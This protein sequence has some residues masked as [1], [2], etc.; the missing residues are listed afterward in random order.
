M[1]VV[2]DLVLAALG[3][4]IAYFQWSAERRAAAEERKEQEDRKEEK[5]IIRSLLSRVA[6]AEKTRG[7]LKRMHEELSTPH[8]DP[9][10]ITGIFDEA[11]ERYESNFQTVRPL[12]KSI[13]D[14]LLKNEERFPMSHG[15]GR[16][17]TELREILNY[18]AV[19]RERRI[20]GYDA[21][22]IQTHEI[23]MDAWN[24]RGGQLREQDRAE[25]GSLAET[26]VQ[27]LE[28]YYHHADRIGSVLY[29]LQAKYRAK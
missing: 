26:M 17:I 22:R 13:Y 14:E 20:L 8:T 15:Y 27:T 11:I 21:A 24:N 7:S 5:V 28:P 2:I 19:V 1:D 18:D 25:L 3:L 23:L 4:I 16:Y 29:E 6:E 9:N 12:L 10:E